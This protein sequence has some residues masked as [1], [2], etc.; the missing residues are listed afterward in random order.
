M[1]RTPK[2]Q[3]IINAQAA[4]IKDL[5]AQIIALRAEIDKLT[6]KPKRVAP[7]RYHDEFS[8]RKVAMRWARM[9]R[10]CVKARPTQR[11]EG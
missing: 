5:D 1:A 9:F 8:T 4:M 11:A 6:P 7:V 10:G 3:E 2:H